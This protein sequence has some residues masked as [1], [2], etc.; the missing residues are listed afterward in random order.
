MIWII[1]GFISIGL[2]AL[3]MS[4]IAWDNYLDGYDKTHPKWSDYHW[5]NMTLNMVI[6]FVMAFVSGPI[7]V[8]ILPVLNLVAW[9]MVLTAYMEK[10]GSKTI[11]DILK[12]D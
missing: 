3:F 12:K 6:L 9:L 10:N 7:G 8:I 4:A 5:K 2:M 11:G 1:G